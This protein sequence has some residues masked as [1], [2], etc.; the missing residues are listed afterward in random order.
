MKIA[1]FGVGLI[2]GSLGLDLKKRGFATQII[3][4]T[5]SEQSAKLSL[6][7]GLVDQIMSKEEAIKN[8]D[9]IVLCVPVNIL[10]SELLFVL[11]RI[12]NQIVVDMGSTKMNIITAIKNHPKRGRFV[13]AHPMAGTENSGPSAAFSGLFDNKICIICNKESSDKDAFDI[14]FKMFTVLGMNIKFMDAQ[15]HDIH[16]AYVSHVSHISSFVLATTV[17]EKEK[18]EEA[19]FEMAGGGF[20]STVRLAKSSPEMWVQIFEQNKDNILEV[21]DTYIVNMYHFRNLIN[22]NKFEELAQ[23]MQNANQI[24]K[25]L[26]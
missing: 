6:E 19:I 10:V 11:D 12:D 25:I 18:D 17:L 24:K 15:A 3:G 23:Y 2:G 9:I 14:I 16:A 26:K 5:R 20:E 13:A 1:I 8:A 7:L 22:K 21:M 4:V